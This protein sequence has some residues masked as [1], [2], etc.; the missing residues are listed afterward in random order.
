MA[1]EIRRLVVFTNGKKIC[2][3]DPN[4][5]IMTVRDPDMKQH[6]ASLD[7]NVPNIHQIKKMRRMR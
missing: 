2:I 7:V 5:I 6:Q 1:K 4:K 3:P